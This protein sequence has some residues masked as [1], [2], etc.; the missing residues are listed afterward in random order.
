MPDSRA[1]LHRQCVRFRGAARDLPAPAVRSL[2]GLDS[3]ARDAHRLATAMDGELDAPEEP[4]AYLVLLSIAVMRHLQLDPVLPAA[5]LDGDRSADD[6]R[7]TY[8]RFDE[9]FHRRIVA[10]E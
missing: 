1:V 3:W 10:R 5:L 6:L 4:P 2:F 9:V 7:R 8:R